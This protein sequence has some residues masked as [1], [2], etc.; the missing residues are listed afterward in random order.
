MALVTA[1]L[2]GWSPWE[3]T[4]LGEQAKAP[5]SLDAGRQGRRGPCW[6]ETTPG[7]WAS[8]VAADSWPGGPQGHLPSCPHLAQSLQRESEEA[9]AAQAADLAQVSRQRAAHLAAGGAD[10][11]GGP[12]GLAQGPAE[13]L[14]VS[15]VELDGVPGP[16]GCPTAGCA[17]GG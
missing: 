2:G 17:R 5:S 16:S 10:A 3:V 12:H 13:L 4:A 8:V 6:R 15:R 9:G 14:Q 1:S 7:T 11:L